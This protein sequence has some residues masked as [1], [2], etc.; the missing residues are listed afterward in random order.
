MILISPLIVLL[1][2]VCVNFPFICN[3]HPFFKDFGNLYFSYLFTKLV[4]E[5][6]LMFLLRL[7]VYHCHLTSYVF[8]ALRAINYIVLLVFYLEHVNSTILLCC[9]DIETNPGPTKLDLYFCYWNLNGI[10]AHDFVKMPL[11]E[12]YVTFYNYD[13]ICLSETFLNSE[14]NNDD[15]RLNIS[16]YNLLRAD[17]PTDTK[18]GGVLYLLTKTIYQLLE[19]TTFAF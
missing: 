2:S 4:C 16:G 19:E 10:A 8:K 5:I 11:I 7:V 6:S 14:I 15:S 17:H 13:I 18:R 12:A 9:G 1:V 3:F